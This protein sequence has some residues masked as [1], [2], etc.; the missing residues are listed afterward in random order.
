MKPAREVKLMSLKYLAIILFV[1]A[2]GSCSG[3]KVI[4]DDEKFAAFYVDLLIASEKSSGDI[5][6]VKSERQKIFTKYDITLE[7]YKATLN[8][9]SEKP[10]RWK[11]FFDKVNARL[12]QLRKNN[13]V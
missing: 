1:F 2:L 4:T 6:M 9:Y 3:R 10:E 8:Y 5:S 12:A 13:K 11:D 7:E